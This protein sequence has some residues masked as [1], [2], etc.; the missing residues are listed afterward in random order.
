MKMITENGTFRKRYPE[1]NCLKTMFLRVRL[2]K[3]KRNFSKTLRSHYQFHSTPRNIRNLFKMADGRFPFLSFNTYASSMRSRVSYRFQID[4]SY[5]CGRAKTMRKRCEN[6]TS[7][8][9]FFEN[10]ETK[11]RFQ[12]N[13]DTCG[14]GPRLQV[15]KVISV[16]CPFNIHRFFYSPSQ[17]LGGECR[18]QAF[19]GTTLRIVWVPVL[20]PDWSRI[21]KCNQTTL[22]FIQLLCSFSLLKRVWWP[23]IH[24]FSF[25]MG[26]F[27]SLK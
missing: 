11:L 23:I 12:T 17:K 25:K 21:S 18:V 4:S 10:G 14:Q 1:W 22:N 20:G 13:S 24:F 15:T 26:N 19:K 5:T 2:D 27:L 7:G 9:G 3:R 6:A 8:R 16:F